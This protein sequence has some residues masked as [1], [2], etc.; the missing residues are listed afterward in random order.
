[1]STIESH[2]PSDTEV[3]R[4]KRAY[5]SLSVAVNAA[6]L[7]TATPG[8]DRMS[9]YACPTC[10]KYHLTKKTNGGDTLVCAIR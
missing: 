8:Y 4:S 9:V 6:W 1:M 5:P 3:C 2:S 7:F 10:S